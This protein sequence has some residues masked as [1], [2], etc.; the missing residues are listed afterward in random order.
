MTS[1][2]HAWRQAVRNE[3]INGLYPS[4]SGESGQGCSAPPSNARGALRSAQGAGAEVETAATAV[5]TAK[6]KA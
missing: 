3:D 1:R 6:S 4:R 2:G 5:R